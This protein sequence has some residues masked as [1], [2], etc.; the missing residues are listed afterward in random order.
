MTRLVTVLD[1]DNPDP[2]RIKT[3]YRL[4]LDDTLIL[5]DGSGRVVVVVSADTPD[6]SDEGE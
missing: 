1:H 3:K 2:A 4:G 6:G 5:R